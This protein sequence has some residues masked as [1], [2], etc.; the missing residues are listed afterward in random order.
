M[1]K[2]ME[3]M[4]AS[5]FMDGDQTTLKRVKKEKEQELKKVMNENDH[6]DEE[7]KKLDNLK[8]SRDFMAMP[9]KERV[10]FLKKMKKLSDMSEKN[11]Q[12]EDIRKTNQSTQLR[13]KQMRDKQYRDSH[14]VKNALK[15][16]EEEVYEAFEDEDFEDPSRL[17]QIK[18]ED[19]DEDID[20]RIN[21]LKVRKE[22]NTHNLDSLREE[23]K[24]TTQKYPP[25]TRLN[26]GGHAG[27]FEDSAESAITISDL[28][29]SDEA[30]KPNEEKEDSLHFKFSKKIKE[31]EK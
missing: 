17:K 28:E 5:D 22:N 12:L 18:E 2:K 9:K 26:A 1:N 24:Q 27:N 11:H 16:K 14:Q 10:L 30:D 15:E 6:I 23:L 25:L 4:S 8:N 7:L 19:E 29:E 13:A 21:N 3:K 20:D 31:L